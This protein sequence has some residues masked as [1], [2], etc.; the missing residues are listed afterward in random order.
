[1]NYVISTDDNFKSYA[2]V[3]INSIYFWDTDAV[4]YVLANQYST[5]IADDFRQGVNVVNINVNIPFTRRDNFHL[6]STAKLNRLTAIPELYNRMD[7][8]LYIDVDAVVNAP[9]KEI[10]RKPETIMAVKDKFQPSVYKQISRWAPGAM[11]LPEYK[12]QIAFNSGVMVFNFE[13]IYKNDIHK[14]AFEFACQHKTTDQPSF[15]FAVAGNFEAIDRRYNWS[16]NYDDLQDTAI[17][18]WHGRYKPWTG[19]KCHKIWDRYKCM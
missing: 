9:L 19:A 12:N 8:A 10:D 13:W 15:N 17:L 1:M 11:L 4:V 6:T 2:Q 14:K 18:H 7:Y 16:V 3:L 5:V